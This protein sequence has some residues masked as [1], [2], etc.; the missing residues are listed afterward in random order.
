MTASVQL[1]PDKTNS[2]DHKEIVLHGSGRSDIREFVPRQSSDATEFGNRRAVYAASDGI[3]PIYF[4]VVDRDGPVT[5]LMNACV[6]VVGADG[7]RSKR[8]YFF[9]INT[10]SSADRQRLLLLGGPPC[11]AEHSVRAEPFQR[12]VEQAHDPL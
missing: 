2:R 12:G 1:S 5:S 7:S 3:W 8:Y 6:R 10:L 11:P 9:S 4:A